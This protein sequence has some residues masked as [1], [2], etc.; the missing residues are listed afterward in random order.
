MVLVHAVIL[1]S[2]YNWIHNE[3][4]SFDDKW[5][6]SGILVQALSSG[7]G[8]FDIESCELF[9]G[10]CDVTLDSLLFL[11]RF[12]EAEFVVAGEDFRR[13]SEGDLLSS[14]V[15]VVVEEEEVVVDEVEEVEE[16]EED[17]DEDEDDDDEDFKEELVDDEDDDDILFLLLPFRWRYFNNWSRLVNSSLSAR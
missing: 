5:R 6:K 12:W 16:V 17:D 9:D 14:V 4:C 3:C 11:V 8:F 7:S 1:K 2:E 13:V 15:V 10:G